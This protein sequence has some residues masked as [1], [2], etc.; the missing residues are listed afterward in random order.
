MLHTPALQRLYDLHQLGLTDRVFIDASHSRL[1]H[2]VGVV[3]HADKLVSAIVHNLTK[4]IEAKTRTTLR[5][6]S[7]DAERDEPIAEIVAHVQRRRA[8]A[9]LM[10]L[11]HDLTHAPYGHTLEDEIGLVRSKHDEPDRQAEAFYR[12]LCQVIG[13]IAR[14]NAVET[15]QADGLFSYMDDPVADPPPVGEV[16]RVAARLL[17]NPML[18]HRMA[19]DFGPQDF[20]RLL[21]DVYVAMQGLLRMELLHKTEDALKHTPKLVP[22]SEPYSFETLIRDTLQAADRACDD[23]FDPYRDAFLIDLIGNTVC[24]DLLDYAQRDA[25]FT[26]IK[27][28]YDPDRIVENFTLVAFPRKHHNMPQGNGRLSDDPFSGSI[29]RPAIALFT[30]KLRTDIPSGVMD[31]LHSRYNLYERALYHSTKCIAGAM[32]GRALQLIDLK[33]VPPHMVFLGDRV[34]LYE[35]VQAA[36]LLRQVLMEMAVQ[37]SGDQCVLNAQAIKSLSEYFAAL[38]A[39]GVVKT[40]RTLL[41]NHK[42][43]LGDRSGSIA[44]F[45]EQL[46]GG[47]RLLDA[48]TARRFHRTVFRLLPNDSKAQDVHEEADGEKEYAQVIAEFFCD[49]DNRVEAEMAIEDAAAL[50]RGSVV[51]HCPPYRGPAKIADVLL[52]ARTAT[53]AEQCETLRGA[54]ALQGGIFKHHVNAVGALQKMYGSTWRLTVSVAPPHFL[55][56]ESLSKTISQEMARTLIAKKRFRRIDIDNDPAMIAEL[57][58]AIDRM[59]PE[60]EEVVTGGPTPEH[61]SPTP[62][63]RKRRSITRDD[64]ESLVF[65]YGIRSRDRMEVRQIV[66]PQLLD[67]MEAVVDGQPDRVFRLAKLLLARRPAHQF[68]FNRVKAWQIADG[69]SQVIA[70]F[71]EESANG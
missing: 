8:S 43:Q 12:L 11:L 46:G 65:Q 45:A 2:V 18:A 30:H 55:K 37:Q 53:G 62:R 69:L 47:I 13:W 17:T 60:K 67:R 33:P 26:N 22:R 54:H 21:S 31:L 32:L 36:R 38:P 1:H 52:L 10:G 19:H 9:R 71:E 7:P 39:M 64:V 4:E 25:H 35:A 49:A 34:F 24:A 6:G 28:T 44:E 16:V 66:I 29:L 58:M 23:E 51:I 70:E 68:C 5:I 27:T 20:Q 40:A 41:E 59:T 15:E 63:V 57:Q 14:G 48:L 56:W 50:P 61:D 3:H 42:R